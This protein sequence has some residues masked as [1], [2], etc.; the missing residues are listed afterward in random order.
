MP[1]THEPVIRECGE[2]LVDLKKAC[3]GLVLRLDGGK[4]AYVRRQVARMLK[5][6]LRSLPKGMTFVIRDAWRSPDEQEGI[7]HG[8]VRR[9][10][11]QHPAWSGARVR[12]EAKKFVAD[13]RGKFASGHMTG[14][15]L[16]LRL[17]KHGRRV[18]MRSRRLSYAEN[19]HP[20]HKKLPAYLLK[21]R[22]IMYQAMSKAGFSQCHN[23]FWHWSYG[24]IYWAM[25][26]GRKTAI[27]GVVE[28]L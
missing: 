7:F 6:A 24:D 28:K 5:R 8:F 25:R 27:Y 13:A 14:G 18:P 17:I 9:F 23:E 15:A 11:R 2:P 10:G 16:D 1:K 12:N 20:H 19:A 26:T 21:N 3:P 4:R 22:Q